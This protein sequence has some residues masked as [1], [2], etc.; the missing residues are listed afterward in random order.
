M[1]AAAVA[2]WRP[3]AAWSSLARRCCS[4]CAAVR[5][6]RTCSTDA[7]DRSTVSSIATACRCTKRSRATATRS[8]RLDR[9]RLLPDARRGHARRGGS[10]L[11][12]APRR[13][14]RRD[15]CARSSATSP[16][17]GS[18]KAVPR[19]R[20][21]PRSCCSTRRTPHRRRGWRAKLQEAVLA[22]RLEHRLTK[23]EILALY[24]NLA[25]YG[26]QIAGAERAS[27]AYFG[28]AAAM[29][30]PAQAAFL[31]G[32]PQRPTALQS[33]PQPRRGAVAP[34]RACCGGWRRAGALTADAGAR[35]ARRAARRSHAR[36]AVSRAALRRDGAGR[37]RATPRPRAIETTLDAALQA[38]VARHHR[39][40][41]RG[42]CDGTA[43]PT[44]PSSVLDNARGEWLAWE[45]RATTSTRTTAARSTARSTPRQPGSALKP[46]TYALG[47]R[48]GLHAGERAARRAVALSDRRAGR[49]LQPAQLRRPLPRAAAARARRS[50]DPRT[51]PR[52]RSRRELGVPDLLRFLR[53]AGLHD[54]R[55]DRRALRPR[56]SRSATRRCGSTSSS[57]R[58]RRSRAAASGSRRP[59]CAAR[60][61]AATTP[62]RWSRPRTAF[63]ITDILSDAEARAYIFGRGGSLEFP[64]PVAVKTGHVAGVSRQLDDR[65][66][67]RRHRRRLGRQLRSHAAAQLD[68]RHGRGADLPRVMLAARA[69]RGRRRGTRATARASRRGRRLGAARDLRAVGHAAN[70]W[71]PARRR[72]WIAAGARRAAVQLASPLAERRAC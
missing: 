3:L 53:R 44:S 61:H 32:L 63:W 60:P 7:V 40:P 37:R 24:L 12:V 4:G 65:L 28:V 49:R 56:R 43:R 70:A 9:G 26:N 51:C 18:S 17:G 6:R 31:A 47:V 68:R 54:L 8:V 11:L 10:P 48:A 15:R 33:L 57:P 21:R 22:L 2:L 69:P 36:P 23:R 25:A 38:D 27:R 72:E 13:R 19:S 39:T 50:P 30:T 67:A 16:S 55:Q 42:C 45:G 14:S 58:T 66:H 41:P 1:A 5:C 64:F 46:F 34:A 29:L 35:G 20:S 62:T 52:S 71:C 59:I